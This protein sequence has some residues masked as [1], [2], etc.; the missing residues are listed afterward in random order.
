ML[1]LGG[2]SGREGV[3]GGGGEG[4]RM[5]WRGVSVCGW[6]AETEREG[7]RQ[8]LAW[9]HSFSDSACTSVESEDRRKEGRART[10]SG[11]S[12]FDISIL[13]ITHA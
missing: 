13:H 12:C 8:W 11:Q 1:W 9:E 7:Q 10:E 6:G 4:V 5:W 3:Q 2:G